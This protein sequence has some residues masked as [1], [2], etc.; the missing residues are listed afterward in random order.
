MAWHPDRG[1]VL[2]GGS[3]GP[4]SDTWRWDGNGWTRL[5]LAPTPGRFNTAMACDP[6][7]GRLVRYGGWDGKRR[8]SD[9]WELRAGGWI[10]LPLEGPPAR[11]HA[12]LVSAPDRGSLLLYGGHDGDAVF[13]DM[14]ELKDGRWTA[15]TKAPPAPRILNGH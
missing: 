15:I 2:F 3:G 12:V 7:T 9:A 6:A 4:L 11:N 13:E 1:V 10:M 5:E 8:V 14:W